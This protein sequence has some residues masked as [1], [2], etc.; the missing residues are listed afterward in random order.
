MLD[1]SYIDEEILLDEE[2]KNDIKSFPKINATKEDIIEAIKLCLK[3]SPLINASN[4]LINSV[5]S[6][7]SSLYIDDKK[8]VI[9]EAPT[10][11]GKTIIGFVVYFCTLYLQQK[12]ENNLIP[13]EPKQEP[14]SSL[15]Y[16]LTSSKMLQEQ[17]DSDLDRFDFRNHISMLKGTINYNCI[18]AT[19]QEIKN[20]KRKAIG[21]NFVD[22]TKVSVK[23]SDRSCIGMNMAER[24]SYFPHCNSICPYQLARSEASEKS[25]SVLN[26]AYFLNVLRSDF[27]PFF[28]IRYLTIADE[29]HLIPDIVC[30]IFN[31]EFTQY[32]CNRI[33]K[34]L[35]ELNFAY[36]A[37]YID[38]VRE[39]LTPCFKFFQT[40]FEN[41]SKQ[42]AIKVLS[43][44]AALEDFEKVFFKLKL[45]KP[46]IL[47]THKV[48]LGK[49]DET[50][51]AILLWFDSMNK[52]ITERPEDVYYESELIAHDKVSDQKVYK[53][54]VKDLSEAE[55]VKK[56]FL[57]KL[58]KGIF[59]SATLGNIDEYAEL[60]GIPKNEY[61]GFRL[62]STFD[63]S[64]SPI[65]ITKSGWLNYA[66][67]D[68]N[69]DKVLMDAIKICENTH[70]KEKGIIHTSTFKICDLLK[71]KIQP[72]I[73]KDVERYL[74]YKT[75]EEKENCVKKLMNSTTPY[76]IIGPSLYEGL[77]LKDDKGRFNILIKAPY[78]QLS[79]YIKKK[80]E[81][82]PFW[83]NRNVLEK[84][85]QAIGRT[86]RS[87][88]DYSKVY[89][90]DSCFDKIIY[91]CNDNITNRIVY[92]SIY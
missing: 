46:E 76:I 27:N 26:Y 45:L 48:Q 62:K 44:F 53:H 86:N 80:I 84:I 88:K 73:V 64:K 33:L 50:L 15:T 61:S 11:S 87:V 74:F 65:S 67:F 10:G 14:F 24:E 83:Y 77:D 29:A 32:L 72:G 69:I 89:L 30:N 52:L 75:S 49:I 36:G 7:L 19:T 57:S 90:L 81:R 20:Q 12:F 91:D 1:E 2:E 79:P 71:Q 40:E 85:V 59:M 34:V 63:F 78:A 68:K 13:G 22:L 41:N 39:K 55:M 21:G 23:Y 58:N 37:Q 31:Y 35:Q 51:K 43:H 8:Y 4:T 54:I 70:P 56:F 18:D 25:C 82:F 5:Y 28:G 66:N 6:I 92:K 3:V 42:N 60:M 47:N 16:F 38:E 9:I 17:I